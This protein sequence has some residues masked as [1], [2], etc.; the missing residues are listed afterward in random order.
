MSIPAIPRTH[1]DYNALR[2]TVTALG[3]YFG[4]RLMTNIRE[5][6]GYT[7]GISAAL[8]GARE[9]GYTM[10]SAQCD[11][12]YTEALIEET[13]SELRQMV[14][15]PLSDDEFNRLKFNV[16]SDLAS[17]LDSPM[18]MMDY[19]ILKRSVGIPD[20]YFE[21]RQAT[22]ATIDPDTIREMSRRYLDPD[23]LRISIASPRES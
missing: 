14:D 8:L 11:D 10:I 2:M 18:T 16:A 1:P 17:T 7:Y 21:A 9:G 15:K 5:D 4:S 3:G 19:Y 20:N 12:R 22:L 6:K 13:K 23:Q